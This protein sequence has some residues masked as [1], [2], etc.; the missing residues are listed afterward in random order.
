MGVHPPLLYTG[1]LGTTVLFGYAVAALVTGRAD[2][3]WA[4]VV[5]PWALWTWATLTAGIVMGAW[6]SYAVLGWGGY[7]AWDPV[8]NAALLPWLLTTALL[9]AGMV[10]R[11]RAG[12]PVW[13]LALAVGAFVM[14][15]L[16]VFLTR[17][18][19]SSSVHAFASS[20]VGVVLLAFLAAVVAGVAALA[21]LRPG[22]IRTTRGPSSRLLSRSSAILANNVLLV[23]LAATVLV[24]TL[25]P[26]LADA[27]DHSQVSVGPSYFD[28]VSIPVV[29][30]LLVLMGVGPYLRWRGDSGGAALRR[31]VV[32]ALAGA[33][34]IVG[35]TLWAPVA[36]GALVTFGLAG[37]VVAGI[38]VDVGRRI[39]TL[40]RP[41]SRTRD[42]AR[43]SA[44]GA[45]LGFV[46][47]LVGVAGSS[48]YAVAGEG[49]IRPGR[50][51]T[52]AGVEV[53]SYA[54]TRQ[55]SAGDALTRAELALRRNGRTARVRPGLRYSPSHDMTVAVPAISSRV[56]GDWYVTL[57][58]ADR[59]GSVTVR[60]A[61]N[62]MVSW[63]WA[64]GALM[65]VGGLAALLTALVRARRRRRPVST[66]V[67]PLSRPDDAAEVPADISSDLVARS[68][69]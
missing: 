23:A 21:L 27:V 11:R 54:V 59:N 42:L 35:V 7:W 66:G 61:V 24:G 38:L 5:R 19:V 4:R 50:H 15:G 46:L 17:S 56:G 10:Q 52:I 63:I 2:A 34:V 31:L 68:E 9:H 1:L 22:G 18:G 36:R 28:T 8:E 55:Q 33:L 37:F 3:R 40:A 25:Y 16:G 20:D 64:G 57:L 44:L 14:A 26:V 69:A 45:H 12:L 62:P 67:R 41:G 39:R 51:R 6:W 48:A 32:P 53:T 13:N 58:S 29:A 30:L 49:T 65:A 60:V 47:L 43:L